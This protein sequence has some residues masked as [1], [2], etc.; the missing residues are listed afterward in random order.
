V[1]WIQH[2]DHPNSR[3][4]LQYRHRQLARAATVMRGTRIGTLRRHARGKKVLDLGCVSHNFHFASGGT[5]RWLHRHIVD[6]AAECVGADYDEVGVKQMADAGFDVVRVDIPY[7]EGLMRPIEVVTEPG[8]VV[9]ARAPASVAAGN[10]ETSQRITDVVLGA[11]HQALPGRI[12]AASSGT[13]NNLTL[14]G[15]DP[16]TGE[17]FAYYET[18]AGGMGARADAAGFDAVHTHM[19]NSL[20]TP[21]EAL[22]NL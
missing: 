12:P 5:G 22:E 14:G 8:T 2:G 10:V 6:A 4:V 11:L 16:R 7:N 17:P 15:V 3:P 19:T 21:V 1:S 13:M 18:I 9:D 20:N